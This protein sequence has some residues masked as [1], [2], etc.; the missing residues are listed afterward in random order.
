MESSGQRICADLT[1]LDTVYSNQDSVLRPIYTL[2][3]SE[4]AD[5]L[6]ELFSWLRW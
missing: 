6:H 1:L 4:K 5:F 3:G 2:T